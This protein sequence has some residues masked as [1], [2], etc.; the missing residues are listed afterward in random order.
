MTSSRFLIIHIQFEDVSNQ[1]NQKFRAISYT[2]RLNQHQSAI[3]APLHKRWFKHKLFD[4]PFEIKAQNP[5]GW[6]PQIYSGTGRDPITNYD[7]GNE[8]FW[9]YKKQVQNNLEKLFHA[10]ITSSP[11]QFNQQLLQFNQVGLFQ[12]R[13]CLLQLRNGLDDKRALRLSCVIIINIIE[14]LCLT[15]LKIR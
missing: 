14:I 11:N 4:Q 15:S 1:E 6:K 2:T 8:S 12:P 10:L 7:K 13:D 3:C 9:G 5:W